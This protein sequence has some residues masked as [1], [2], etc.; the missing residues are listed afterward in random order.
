MNK[1]TIFSILLCISIFISSIMI[2][3]IAVA[4]N[5]TNANNWST[6]DVRNFLNG[7]GDDNSSSYASYF[8]DAEYSVI[9]PVEI[10]NGSSIDRFYL[11]GLVN[12]YVISWKTEEI[13]LSSVG[14]NISYIIPMAYWAENGGGANWMRSAATSGDEAYT[15]QRGDH[16]F[17]NVPVST[18][19]GVAPLFHINM[20]SVIFA[21][22]ASAAELLGKFDA[23][24][25]TGFSIQRWE[26]VGETTTGVIPEYGMYLKTKDSNEDFQVNVVEYSDGKLNLQYE[27]ADVG[28][29]IVIQMYPKDNWSEGCVTYVAASKIDNAS[30]TCTID[31]SNSG[32]LSFDNLVMQIWMED[33]GTGV[34]MAQATEPQSF[35][36]IGGSFTEKTPSIKNLRVFAMEDE[37]ACSWGDYTV[38]GF[39]SNNII[40][41][42]INTS[43]YTGF[44]LDISGTQMGPYATNQKIYFGTDTNGRPLA[45][46]IAGCEETTG[47]MCLYQARAVDQRAFKGGTYQSA[48]TI[49]IMDADTNASITNV[50]LS[51][52]VIDST[53]IKVSVSGGD[54][55]G[56]VT[57]KSSN[58]Y[59][60]SVDANGVVT[61]NNPG[62]FEILATK[63]ASGSSYSATIR[64]EK[65]VVADH[66][67]SA[68]QDENGTHFKECTQEG[69]NSRV[70][71]HTPNYVAEE[72]MH[73][74]SYD[75]CDFSH[76]IVW[77]KK[78]D[79]VHACTTCN[80]TENH[81]GEAATCD[82][83][84]VCSVCNSEYGTEDSNNHEYDLT[85]W[86]YDT[87]HHWHACAEHAEAVLDK[88]A[89]TW[90]EWTTWERTRAAGESIKTRS[91]MVCDAVE[92]EIIQNLPITPGGDTEQTPG[93]NTPGDNIE[94]NPGGNTSGDNIEQN[95]GGN[96]TIN[97]GASAGAQPDDAGQSPEKG[98]A[99]NVG[100]AT[101]ITVVSPKTGIEESFVY[102]LSV[103]VV[104]S[105]A[106]MV[107]KKRNIL[108]K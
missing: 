46:W 39:D 44:E 42:G 18:A 82:K 92:T 72:N 24:D 15:Y 76:S 68:F 28:K 65:I 78:D 102:I 50:G 61:I 88:E 66:S 67:Y 8:T 22:F 89:H 33:P 104:F 53:P 48:L 58:P 43:N 81:T 13:D 3:P 49:Q 60:A 71:S 52:K 30:G 105:G 41:G 91:C 6:S 95:P 5:T 20:D 87:T 32:T 21:S 86:K 59:V 93:G 1:K 64:S 40:N 19:Y 2:N 4:G 17:A 23:V 11:P 10:N 97:G 85:T 101:D 75:G 107:Y 99:G 37:L 63:S 73:V 12:D 14:A 47:N 29:A 38:S 108:K 51:C 27:N 79:A 94:Q 106:V 56:T 74:C 57:Y 100:T 80:L 98:Q 7:S 26:N 54:N 35:S 70:E 83:A 69:C 84:A 77:E 36:F 62:T 25:V 9:L 96:Q 103:F 16:V 31:F 34:S 55:N 45:H 90:S